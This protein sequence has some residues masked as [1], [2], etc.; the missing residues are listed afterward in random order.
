LTPQERYIHRDCTDGWFMNATYVSFGW[1]PL[2]NGKQARRRYRAG[3]FEQGD[4]VDVLLELGDV[5]FLFFGNGAQHGPG[6]ATG[7]V[8]GP[9][10]SCSSANVQDH[11]RA[12][13]TA[14]RTS[15]RVTHS[16]GR[17]RY[18]AVWRAK[19]QRMS[20]RRHSYWLHRAPKCALQA[21]AKTT[22]YLTID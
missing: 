4:R 3:G 19:V 16:Q 12:A 18:I 6:Y 8:S 1:S 2:G 13:T 7:S 15:A 17:R 20:R 11:E 5:S 10:G 14:K 22:M 9:A 21:I